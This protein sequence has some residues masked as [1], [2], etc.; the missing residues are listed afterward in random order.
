[1]TPRLQKLRD[2]ATTP[3][4][5]SA[6]ALVGALLL[7]LV[8]RIRIGARVEAPLLLCDEFIYAELSQSFAEEGR[9]L[10]RG[11]PSYQSLV[12]PILL[13]PAWLADSVETAYELAKTINAV[14]LAAAAV[15]IYLW[16]RGLVSPGWAL[17]PPALTLLM[18]AQLY[19]GLILSENA[20][21]PAFVLAAYAVARAIELPSKRRQLLALVAIAAACGVRMQGIVL[22]IILPTAV[23]AAVLLEARLAASGHRLRRLF[24]GLRAWWPSAAVLAGAA[25][26][27]V[28]VQ[29]A[30]GE[31]FSE[32]FGSYQAVITRGYT[33]EGGWQSGRLH[34]AALALSVG[35][36]PLSALIVLAARAIL[37]PDRAS[38]GLRALMAV[39]TAS[40]FWLV[41]EVGLFISRFGESIAERY[42]FYVSPLLFLVLAVWLAE[43]LPRPWLATAAGALF[44]ATLVMSEPLSRHLAPGLLI[45]S[46]TLFGFF[47]YTDDLGGADNLVWA[48]RLGALVAAVSFAVL[49]RPLATVLIPAGI[50]VFFV[51]MQRPG[52][53][54]L[55]QHSTG[56]R[57][58]P[59]IGE[60]ASWVDHRV[61]RDTPVDFLYTPPD[62]GV[63]DSSA[64][65]LQL[66]FWNRSLKSIVNVG[67]P[68]VCPL[69]ERA[70]RIDFQ[71]GRITVP[72]RAVSHL[73]VDSNVRLAGT[74]LSREGP[75]VLYRIAPPLSLA[76]ATDGV[77]ADGWTGA[78]ASFTQYRTPHG[79]PGR[80]AVGISRA[81][82]TGP[83]V[84]GNVTVRVGKLESSGA[85]RWTAS[86]HFVIH[87]RETRSVSLPTPKPVFRVQVNV[88]PTFSPSS[89]GLP[90][91]RQLGVQLTYRFVR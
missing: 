80:A 48:W 63:F 78:E 46:F 51:V 10:L 30:R 37:H 73:V 18:P 71:S 49:W 13:A 83:D 66:K 58:A 14:L 90:D 86:R 4:A 36:V 33:L 26:G 91:S 84:P 21:L 56:V 70:A 32:G 74:A 47:G 61:G 9:L 52:D 65:M 43:G 54:L 28:I 31:S 67:T 50:A 24:D 82:W 59:A 27:Y 39:V 5:F 68:E 23:F 40:T 62:E 72:G 12:Y 1:V 53:E 81:T 89:F 76:S 19:S 38:A 11:E 60:T 57:R 6:L 45:N 85:I 34:L 2:R 88:D 15:L 64:I 44:P 42:I 17:L 29:L 41:V 69:P 87:S 22:L 16:G 79:R 3:A 25:C 75:F 20:F 77:F 55:V 35:L 7:A 8:V